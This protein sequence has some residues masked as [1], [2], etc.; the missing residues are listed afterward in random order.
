MFCLTG[1]TTQKRS[2]EGGKWHSRMIILEWWACKETGPLTDCT[3]YSPTFSGGHTKRLTNKTSPK[4]RNPQGNQ[5][6][7]HNSHWNTICN[8]E[9]KN[10]VMVENFYDIIYI[11]FIIYLW[12]YLWKIDVHV[13]ICRYFWIKLRRVSKMSTK[14]FIEI[15]IK[16]WDLNRNGN[17][18]L[19]IYF[20]IF[21]FYN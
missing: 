3:E 12:F 21:K 7:Y 2:G 15:T 16:D 5:C 9:N 11:K 6:L 8:E 20:F 4:E 18:E 10:K 1:G 13:Y 19:F 17:R 14:M